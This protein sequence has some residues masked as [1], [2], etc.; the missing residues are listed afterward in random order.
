[1]AATH[2]LSKEEVHK[3][4]VKKIW[5]VFWILLGVTALEFIVALGVGREY[6]TLKVAG[7]IGMTIIKAFYIMGEFMHLKGEV[8]SLIWSILL[9]IVFVAWLLIA[10]LY[11]GNS[12]GL[13]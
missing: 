2:G 11:E 10:L 13:P 6:Y 3:Q 12:I 9:P 1:M 8:K 7:F 4:H 5:Q